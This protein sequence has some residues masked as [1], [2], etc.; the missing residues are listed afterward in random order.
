ML[1]VLKRKKASDMEMTERKK[2]ILAAVVERYILSGE[3]VGSKALVDLPG[4][5]VSSATVRNDMADLVTA[6]YLEQ[7]HTSAGRIPSS[8]GYR[9]YVDNLMA[10]MSFPIKKNA[11][12]TQS[13]RAFRPRQRAYSEK[14]DLFYRSLRAALPFPQR[15]P[16]ARRLYAASSLSP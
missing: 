14:P 13:L 5:S 11:L 6:G 1:T 3:P 7:P 8:E 2:K 4:L 15:L 10:D 9:Y 16:T 12:L